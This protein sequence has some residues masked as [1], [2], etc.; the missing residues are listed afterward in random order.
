MSMNRWKFA[1][2]AACLT[3][4]ASSN[5][6][7]Q[8]TTGGITGVVSGDNG[9]P[10]ENAQVQ[11]VNRATG[12]T[13][14][15]V[16]RSN[17][18][19][20]VQ[21][22]EV[23]RN[24]AV[25]VR[26]LG[27]TPRTVEPV[28]VT[29][30]QATTV[31][32]AISTQATTLAAVTVSASGGSDFAATRQGVQTVISDTLLQRLP[33]LDRDFTSLV[34]LTPQ[35]T[36]QTGGFSAAGSNPR[37]SQFTIDGANQ[38][39]RFGLN[40][41]GGLPGGGAG[42]RI[43][44]ID[45]VK[46]VQVSLTPT[47]VRQGNFASV[48]VNAVTRSGTNDF[49]AGA[50]Y[51]FRNPSL[52]RD[53]A[54]IR[55]GNLRQ[56]QYGGFLGGPI[57]RDR[58]H[59]FGAIEFQ[60]RDQPNSGPSFAETGAATDT[61]TGGGGV[62]RAQIDRVRS[63]A[64]TLGIDAGTA[65]VLSLETPLTNFIGRLDF[66]LN[67]STR[68]VLRQLVN[69]ATQT[70]FSRNGTTFN[71]DANVQGTGIRLTS[72]RIPR[73][74]KN[75][76]SVFQAFTNL[77]S[78]IANEFSAAYNRVEDV[79]TPPL[80]TPEI[81]VSTRGVNGANSQITFG[82][83]QFSSVNLLKQNVVELTDNLTIPFNSHTFTVGGRISLTSILNDFQQRSYGAYKFASIDSL[84]RG[85]PLSYSVAYANG[86][87]VVAD[88]DAQIFS[89]YVQDQWA[90]TN[91]FTLT[92]GLRVDVP[93]LPT[94]PAD[95]PNISAGFAAKGLSV[96]TT[97]TP[98]TRP[99]FSPRL[100][101]N[102]DV[103]G[104]QSL[105]LRGNG[106]I[107]TGEP[108]YILIGN[109]YANTGRG[110]ALL[111]C[112]SAVVPAFTTDVS[113]LPRS[114]AGQAA[115][116]PGAAGTAGVNLNDPNFKYPQ[117]FVTS[118]GVDYLLPGGVVFT[119][120]ALYGR[121]VNGIRIRDLNLLNARGGNANPYT[122]NTGRV[123]YADTIT[124]G[125]TSL[126]IVNSGQRAIITNGTNNAAFSEGAIQ[127]TNQSKGYNYAFTPQLKKRFSRGVDLTTSYTYTRAYE[128]QAFTSDRAISIW[129][130]GREYSGLQD[131][132]EL[133]TSAYEQ[134][135]R[136]QF[137]GSVT[138]PWKRFPT[139]LSLEYNGNSGSPIT[140]TVNG[141]LNGDGFNAND[142][143]Y[144]PRN[145]TDVNEI[146]IVTLRNPGAAFNATTN[147]Y[148]PNAAAAQRYERF[149]SA[150]SCL[151]EQRGRIMERNTCRNPW[152]NL[153]NV[154][155]RQTLPEFRGNRFIAQLDVFNFANLLNEKWGVNKGTI[156][157]TFPQQQI[158]IARN[159]AAG[160]ISNE[161]LIGYEFDTRLQDGNG[162]PRAYQNFVN[163]LGNVYRM[164]LTFKYSY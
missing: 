64:Q 109:A 16:T 13:T 157:S 143:V 10:L 119:G 72:N 34:R 105:Q 117:R 134:R 122:T 71:A 160:P 42:G 70:D 154:S 25:T 4:A 15:Q 124:S 125:G 112:A 148:E 35:V 153:F 21:N 23:G 150:F 111:T 131:E 38:S 46:E 151:N 78:G 48:L 86:P 73:E 121:D 98:K 146:R 68:M 102:W 3:A 159:R 101:M 58:L 114:C 2:A 26:L 56:Q 106:G 145:A 69:T 20:F 80:A 132:D 11:V 57:I 88:F 113:N 130:N 45:A 108:P 60:Q 147:P 90:P 75:Y 133:T 8:T 115:P 97:G 53:T 27:Y 14:G 18:R 24:Y 32:L 126:T 40:S 100:G 139:D 92:G 104:N 84:A 6:Y 5:T 118:A 141:D 128:V 87:G 152:Q 59:F 37:L 66:R 137:Y 65:Q 144:I 129:R 82:T 55:T 149:I 83:E 123:L 51:T 43:V 127:L 140:Y 96:S 136:V 29:L 61:V 120:E 31:N 158:L 41:T 89:G 94:T 1:V 93:R 67:N 47:D 76:S 91:R 81:S 36:S 156:I 49:T 62:T 155:V 95:N 107:Y 103:R 7:A 39:D 74:N 110:L 17:G 54:Y 135:H 164:Q 22:L 77:Q 9:A 30:G 28:V 52:A 44:P 63:V 50:T 138:A 161:S 19:F 163:S 99:L 85:Q 116:Q 162:N 79:R 33:N 142:P 12:F